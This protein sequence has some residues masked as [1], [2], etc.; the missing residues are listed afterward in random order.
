MEPGGT[1]VGNGTR[2]LQ[3]R[4][5]ATDSRSGGS[6]FLRL[7]AAAPSRAPRRSRLCG[8]WRTSAAMLRATL[9]FPSLPCD[10]RPFL[11]LPF[12]DLRCPSLPCASLSVFALL[13]P[14]PHFALRPC[15]PTPTLPYS[16]SYSYSYATP[17]PTLLLP[18]PYATP[19]P[20]P[21]PTPTLPYPTLPY[22][23]YAF[24]HQGV[25]SVSNTTTA[26]D[27]MHQV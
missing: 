6:W 11:A 12:F 22:P 21:T 8:V 18:L 20:T 27:G 19:T 5:V 9:R 3:T 2:G 16:Y 23:K 17:T 7:K 10:A 26:C 25:R 24:R 15:T 13:A 4:L 14:A 1:L